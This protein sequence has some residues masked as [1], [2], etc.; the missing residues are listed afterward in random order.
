[1]L[2]A[3]PM[4]LLN[5]DKQYASKVVEGFRCRRWWPGQR[6]QNSLQS[7]D[8]GLK[9]VAKVFSGYK[10]TGRTSLVLLAVFLTCAGM[11]WGGDKK[12]RDPNTTVSYSPMPLDSGYGPM[13]ITEPPIPPDE[14]VKKFTAKESVFRE[15]LNHY[16]YRRTVRVQTIND[17]GKVDGE[18]Y[19]VDDIIFTPDGKRADKVVEAPP[20]PLQRES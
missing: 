15:A 10:L 2:R 14:I 20:N 5:P 9:R 3:M 13:D 19:Q 8:S 7:E 17:D 4:I 16:T 6:D 18:Y 1:M 12:K 11:A